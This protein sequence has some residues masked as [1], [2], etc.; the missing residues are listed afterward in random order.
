MG[1]WGRGY[2]AGR[3]KSEEGERKCAG[4]TGG[5]RAGW[6]GEEKRR[7]REIN[8]RKIEADFFTA[9]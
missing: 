2:R 8:E 5:K 9:C 3:K 7:G 4:G 1:L 6:S